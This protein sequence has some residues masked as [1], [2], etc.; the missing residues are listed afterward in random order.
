MASSR[1]GIAT[2]TLRAWER[3]YGFPIPERRAGGSRLYSEADIAK[4]QLLAS[5]LA[6]GFRPGDVVHLE[7]VE[8]QRLTERAAK[9]S[10]A[11][12]PVSTAAAPLDDGVAHVMDALQR[13]DAIAVR[14]LLHALALQLGPRDFVTECAHP[15]IVR[16][17][18]AW[19][20]GLLDVRHEHLASATLQTELRSVL[21][22]L[23][24]PAGAKVV[25]LTTLPEEPHSLPLDLIAVYLAAHGIAPRLLGPCTPADQIVAAAVAFR[26]DAVGVS[27]S[28]EA[29]SSSTRHELQSLR[30]TLPA[31]VPLWVGGSG[32]RT[33]APTTLRVRVVD[34]WR[35][36]DETVRA[37]GE[38][39]PPRLR[40]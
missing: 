23:A 26:A 35:L 19:A 15:L 39:E 21:A 9:D 11:R 32:A 10:G 33:L 18:A 36:L 16:V 2:E 6:A 25:L 3:R 40:P 20:E 30:S 28:V 1:T 27:V 5:A 13:D 14:A 12:Q 8:L 17:G 24:E 29:P 31:R 22:S 7:L 34:S 4:L 38:T 37:L